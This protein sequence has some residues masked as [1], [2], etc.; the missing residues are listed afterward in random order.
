MDA[1]VEHRLDIPSARLCRFNCQSYVSAADHV[2]E[3][4]NEFYLFSPLFCV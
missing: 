1:R 3:L 2:G 4:G